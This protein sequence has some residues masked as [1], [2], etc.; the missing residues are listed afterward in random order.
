[1]FKLIVR[2]EGK[3][4]QELSLNSDQE[5]M[6]GRDDS[7]QIQLKGKSGIS[8]QHFKIYF[9]GNQW[10]V[11]VISKF[12]HL[13]FQAQE[14]NS[15]I[16]ENGYSFSL[17]PF[18]F[19]FIQEKTADSLPTVN[20]DGPTVS[21]NLPANVDLDND[22]IQLDEN[23]PQPVNLTQEQ[24]EFMG[25]DEKTSIGISLG[26]PTI[27]I[28]DQTGKNLGSFLL[29]DGALWI[30]GR[31]KA[32]DIQI[33][34]KKASRKHF[35]ISKTH[36]GFVIT[37]LGSSNGTKVNNK[38]V[39]PNSSTLLA[40]GD[41]ISVASINII[42]EVK[43]SA[44]EQQLKNL[45]E[46]LF[47]QTVVSRPAHNQ[48]ML[49]AYYEDGNDD[50]ENYSEPVGLQRVIKEINLNPRAL[51]LGI[52]VLFILYILTSDIKDPNDQ[53]SETSITINDNPINKLTT[54][55]KQMVK[56]SYASAQS[57]AQKGNWQLAI[58]ELEKIHK[59]LPFYERSKELE[60]HCRDALA[61]L[62]E[63]RQI[64]EENK[65]AEET[66]KYIATV[67][68]ACK[69]KFTAASTLNDI[70]ACLAPALE[71]DPENTD[72]ASLVQKATQQDEAR[73][74]AASNARELEERRRKGESLFAKGE[75]LEKD[76]KLS[77]AVKVYA[78]Y[79]ANYADK[80]MVAQEKIKSLKNAIVQNIE[81]YLKEA[82]DHSTRE[83]YRGA[84]Y[85]INVAKTI[86]ESDSRIRDVETGILAAQNRKLLSLYQD[87]KFEES[88]GNV[89]VTKEK[90]QK[91]ME[92]SLPE[93][94]FHNKCKMIL[95]KYGG[96]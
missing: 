85:A 4:V 60:S 32:C 66:R 69:S 70:N 79:V 82:Q 86:D 11:D 83:D 64:E 65:R 40:S 91:I 51:L 23:L 31:D 63:S 9:N 72:V 3:T 37:D 5:Y 75:K 48:S 80:R 17:A 30:A 14:V 28:V 2:C 53:K 76:K 44:V 10:Q 26:E 38:K 25:D 19:Q 89:Q 27:Q 49:P 67:V 56:E 36:Q 24:N 43:N 45:P 87:A 47:N 42:F 1:M 92:L 15:I 68:E 29:K 8:R 34:D 58:S 57:L 6:A 77:D 50:G 52:A 94:D 96:S 22:T 84:L 20:K 74:I 62:V 18:D 93:N 16:L 73:A 71:R 81:K 88:L 55:Q 35:E 90:C 33:P 13:N 54:E 78:E 7:C 46:V 12:G 21:P 95:K 61:L 59:L 39:S 41:K